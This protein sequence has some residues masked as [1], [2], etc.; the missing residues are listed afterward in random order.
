MYGVFSATILG[1]DF[2]I[3][4]ETNRKTR[5]LETMEVVTEPADIGSLSVYYYD[6][7]DSSRSK[8]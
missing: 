5:A 8:R 2:G 6:L 4:N 7:I 3:S 1:V